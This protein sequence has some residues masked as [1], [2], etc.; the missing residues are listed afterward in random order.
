MAVDDALSALRDGDLSSF[1]AALQTAG[2]LGNLDAQPVTIFA[3]DNSAFTSLPGTTLKDLLAD[4]GKIKTILENHIVDGTWT[5][6]KLATVS[7]LT[8]K[9]GRMLTVTAVGGTVTVDGAKVVKADSSTRD[10]QVH[11]IDKVLTGTAG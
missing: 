9:S 7:S 8:A 1:V 11:V 2:L 5:A 3:P 6:E 10:V 4:P